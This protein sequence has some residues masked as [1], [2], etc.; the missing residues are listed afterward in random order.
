MV[1]EIPQ[2]PWT[3][4]S[5]GICLERLATLVKAVR[6]YPNVNHD[7]CTYTTIDSNQGTYRGGQEKVTV[8]VVGCKR[9]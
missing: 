6:L 8:G 9:Q 3:A 5:R 1:I 2:V 7:E 4:S